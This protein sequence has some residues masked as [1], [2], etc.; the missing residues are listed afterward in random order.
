MH[1]TSS[2][3][4]KSK[5]SETKSVAS[6]DRTSNQ[7]SSTSQENGV[8]LHDLKPSQ[9]QKPSSQEPKPSTQVLKPF[10]NLHGQL[11][12]KSKETLVPERNP[13]KTLD[14]N[15]SLIPADK[16]PSQL[17]PSPDAPVKNPSD[18]DP[19]PSNHKILND[20]TLSNPMI[21]KTMHDDL[22]SPE[23]KLGLDQNLPPVANPSQIHPSP[24]DAKLLND[25]TLSNPPNL[26]P[27]AYDLDLRSHDLHPRTFS[28]RTNPPPL[29]L[30]EQM[31][32]QLF[33]QGQV[34]TWKGKGQKGHGNPKGQP[35]WN[36]QYQS[37]GRNQG[38]TYQKPGNL[39]PLKLHGKQQYDNL[40]ANKERDF[41]GDNSG[42]ERNINDIFPVSK[43]KPKKLRNS[44][45]KY[46]PL[47]QDVESWNVAKFLDSQ[48]EFLKAH[49]GNR[50][51][52]QDV[53]FFEAPT[54][55]YEYVHGQDM[56]IKPLKSIAEYSNDDIKEYPLDHVSVKNVDYLYDLLYK[57]ENRKSK[58]A[59]FSKIGVSAKEGSPDIFGIYESNI[60]IHPTSEVQ[61]SENP[62]YSLQVQNNPHYP[63]YTGYPSRN[64]GTVLYP[65]PS[66]NGLKHQSRYVTGPSFK[67]PDYKSKPRYEPKE[68]SYK[69]EEP[70][71]EPE[72]HGYGP[73]KHG[74]EPE[75]H[76]YEPEEPSYK[77][78]E[79]GY[80]PEPRYGPKEPRY[81]PP[82]YGPPRGPYY[83][84][85][86]Y[87]PQ[88]NRVHDRHGYGSHSDAP[89]FAETVFGR[90][91]NRH[92]GGDSYEPRSNYRE[93]KSFGGDYG[94]VEEGLFVELPAKYPIP[95]VSPS[96]P[97]L[98]SNVDPEL[99]V[100]P[101]IADWF[102]GDDNVPPP[103]LDN[104]IP[105]M[106]GP[107]QFVNQNGRQGQV[108]SKYGRQ[109]QKEKQYGYQ[110]PAGNQH[111]H[112]GD[113]KNQYGGHSMANQYGHYG[114]MNVQYGR[115][116]PNQHG[117]RPEQ[118][119]TQNLPLVPQL[120]RHPNQGLFHQ[121]R[122]PMMRKKYNE[123]VH[124]PQGN[125][126][127]Y[128]PLPSQLAPRSQPPFPGP[129]IRKYPSPSQQYSRSIDY[130]SHQRPRQASYQKWL[131]EIDHHPQRRYSGR[132][133]PVNRNQRRNNRHSPR[134][135]RYPQRE[136]NKQPRRRNH[137]KSNRK[138]HHQ[139]PHEH[140]NLNNENYYNENGPHNEE[141]YN[142]KD[143][144][145]KEG[146][147]EP[148]GSNKPP[149]DFSEFPFMFLP[150]HF[151]GPQFG[152][153]SKQNDEGNGFDIVEKNDMKNE[154]SNVSGKNKEDDE[155]SFFH[156][157]E[158]NESQTVP[159]K[160]SIETQN[161][162]QNG[163]HNKAEMERDTQDNETQGKHKKSTSGTQSIAY[164]YKD[165]ESYGLG[166]IEKNEGGKGLHGSYTNEVHNDFDDSDKTMIEHS[167]EANGRNQRSKYDEQRS[168]RK[169][170]QNTN[171]YE[172]EITSS[173]ER[174][175][176]DKYK[177]VDEDKDTP[178]ELYKG[179][180]ASSEDKSKV[181]HIK[182]TTNG[183]RRHKRLALK[184]WPHPEWLV[185]GKTNF[186]VQVSKLEAVVSNL[187][188]INVTIK[189]QL[190]NK[191]KFY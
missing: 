126:P 150:S 154:E 93:G 83:E 22:K 178:D 190:Q 159:T 23:G 82:R 74:Y 161:Y 129:V 45:T 72:E 117:S 29:S 172:S 97:S 41:Y 175:E 77:H 50:S 151:I 76:G 30:K 153:F 103:S 34:N 176:K 165:D 107:K 96:D 90:G 95:T 130:N 42:Q 35:V 51:N 56:D 5:A 91:N 142:E 146:N 57:P 157:V 143:P 71:Y 135:E 110:D 40:S 185:N 111:G 46:I 38:H 134:N 162:K 148:S 189:L 33:S 10:N 122:Q 17:D 163:S 121:H 138:S 125:S 39:L 1:P 104:I 26:H 155:E 37:Q 113:V 53:K 63:P 70:R 4:V 73:E 136:H 174:N 11:K 47:N 133:N 160:N 7:P 2:D 137:P 85:P 187:I 9:E 145:Q 98:S 164:E 101:E 173:I 131:Q 149:P 52:L 20:A 59:A 115:Q 128:L 156:I 12:S 168:P 19:S 3:A 124:G 89:S 184:F 86:G 81:E 169:L 170:H 78:E 177:V 181:E 166:H 14:T 27:R 139:S 31:R 191:T 147:Q 48:N 186:S 102:Y 61:N 75:G 21:L 106:V 167:F 182:A 123:I 25:V 60:Q 141:Y 112:Q 188:I 94:I 58:M 171:E 15:A 105:V 87:G 92:H 79:H 18:A 44:P 6:P 55:V 62:S 13:T 8:N 88:N 118:L 84:R 108:E 36:S 183:Q 28:H 152:M 68:P 158:E 16:N 69:H 99:D 140:N 24:S 180:D 66:Y 49:Y 127:R 65:Y 109:G 120:N 100:P 119:F 132:R 32:L 67:E 64:Q 114:L 80:E 43:E 116:G 179:T 144:D 54:K